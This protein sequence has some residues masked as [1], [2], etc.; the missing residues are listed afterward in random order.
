MR[1]ATGRDLIRGPTHLLDGLSDVR[2]TREFRLSEKG[3]ELMCLISESEGVSPVKFPG[4][5]SLQDKDS[6]NALMII[7]ASFVRS[8]FDE[9]EVRSHS[10]RLC[11]VREEFLAILP[12]SGRS[13]TLGNFG[14]ALFFSIHY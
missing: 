7:R 11:C 6:F 8:V 13:E 1:A 12:Q 4:R 2:V 9:A 5:T 10:D 14:L 3:K